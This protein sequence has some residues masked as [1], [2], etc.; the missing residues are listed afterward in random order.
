M[1]VWT[2]GVNWYHGDHLKLM[3]NYV[4]ASTRHQAAPAAGWLQVDPASIQMRAQLTW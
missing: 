3:L 2:A 1:D 4:D